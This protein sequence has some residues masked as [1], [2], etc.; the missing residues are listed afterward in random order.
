MH[1]SRIFGLAAAAAMLLL[2]A[3]GAVTAAPEVPPGVITLQVPEGVKA[4]RPKVEFRHEA[5]AKVD[6]ALC[7]HKWD[8]ASDVIQSCSAD[9]CHNDYQDKRGPNG[10]YTAFH[11]PAKG[12]DHAS[13]MSC[14]RERLKAGEPAG[15][16]SCAKGNSCHLDE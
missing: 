2:I 15:P 10:Y 9:G 4:T 14:H 3:I 13:C 1:G 16:T 12:L 11:S 6:C 7:H 8:G 5:H